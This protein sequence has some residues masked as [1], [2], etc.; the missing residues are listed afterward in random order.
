L[1]PFQFISDRVSNIRHHRLQDLNFIQDKDNVIKVCHLH[2]AIICFRF[3]YS[4]D[5]A[6]F[7]IIFHFTQQ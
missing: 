4:F 3:I 7:A 5:C 6:E 2:F 1:Y